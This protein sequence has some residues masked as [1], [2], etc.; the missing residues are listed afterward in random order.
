MK[1]SVP[2]QYRLAEVLA[3]PIVIPAASQ[4]IPNSGQQITPTA[5]KDAHFEYL[6]AGLPDMPEHIAG[7]AVA[8]VVS[9]DGATLLVLTSGYN[10]LRSSKAAVTPADSTQFV[11]VYDISHHLHG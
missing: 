8:S 9:P 4:V 2:I 3:L 5:S 6:K 7:G 10:L 11:F 1:S